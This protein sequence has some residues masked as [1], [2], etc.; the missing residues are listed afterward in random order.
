LVFDSSGIQFSNGVKSKKG[1]IGMLPLL[2]I[3]AVTGLSIYVNYLRSEEITWLTYY[4]GTM[5][6]ILISGIVLDLWNW[7]SRKREEKRR[8]EESI[9]RYL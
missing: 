7:R 4:M 8:K 9:T 1:G 3:L 6:G 5:A 2:F